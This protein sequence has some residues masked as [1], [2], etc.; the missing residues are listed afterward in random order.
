MKN[1]PYDKQE[2]ESLVD[3]MQ[4]Q[5]DADTRQQ[6]VEAIA[7]VLHEY[8]VF[9]ELGTQMSDALKAALADDAYDS[10][11]T[12]EAFCEKLT[13]DLQAI[14]QDKHLRV[15][16]NEEPRPVLPV[17]TDY[18]Y[19]PEEIDSWTAMGRSKNFGFYK[20]ERLEGNIG[21]LDLR[22][23]W[24]AS[25][26]GAG[27]T[28]AGVMAFLANMDAM[29]IDLRQN[30]GGSP[31]MVALLMSYL[32]KPE[33]VHLNSFYDRSSDNT[34]QS[35]T[36][37]YVPGRR[38]PEMP[39]YVLTSSRTFSGAEEFTY[40]LKNMKRATI[41]G[42]TTGG[43]AH[44]GRDVSVTPHFRVFVPMGR[45]I[46][47]ISGTNW[48]GTGI[49]PDVSVPQQEAFDEAYKLALQMVIHKLEGVPGEAA[50][51]QLSEAK[52][53]LEALDAEG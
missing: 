39:V 25:W 52:G 6:V 45:P 18:T 34:M 40:N 5:V 37:P 49:E 46:N 22:N 29:L 43:G 38:M 51:G 4:A 53:A 26:A 36:L 8:Y 30:G 28:A 1:N 35:W 20:I 47:P 48:E 16:F 13:E 31:S 50:K 12:A 42:E 41:I 44:P 21:Y 24:E 14:G 10:F 11:T 17:A 2:D 23:F 27:E 19:T 15:R 9:P 7:D 33:S 3:E 32:L